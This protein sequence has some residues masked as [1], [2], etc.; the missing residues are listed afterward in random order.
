MFERGNK[1]EIQEVIRFYGRDTILDNINLNAKSPFEND[2][3]AN[4]KQYLD[5][6]A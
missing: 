4:I 5:Y 1:A 3:K 2:I 6:E